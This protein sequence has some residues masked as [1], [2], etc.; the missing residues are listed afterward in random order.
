MDQGIS[1]D[2]GEEI[3]FR[4]KELQILIRKKLR[5]KNEKDFQDKSETK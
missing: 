4:L 1:Q 3:I 2:I 5:E